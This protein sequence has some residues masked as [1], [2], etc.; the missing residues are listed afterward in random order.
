MASRWELL[1]NSTVHAAVDFATF[2]N[3]ASTH[4]KVILILADD[5]KYQ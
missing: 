4:N 3:A 2:S 1:S 5:S